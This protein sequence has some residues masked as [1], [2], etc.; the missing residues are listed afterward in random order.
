MASITPT[1]WEQLKLYWSTTAG[2][3]TPVAG[4]LVGEFTGDPSFDIKM[5]AVVWRGQDRFPKQVAFVDGESS[6]TIPGMQFDPDEAFSKFWTMV[7]SAAATLHG[8]AAVATSFTLG[9]NVKPQ[10]AEFLI[11]GLY[12]STGKKAQI[13]IPKGYVDSIP[14]TVGRSAFASWSLGLKCLQ[15]ASGNSLKIFTET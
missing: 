8:G 6:V 11:E 5:G 9:A 10:T 3:A 15:D 4:N 2:G 7:K 13:L 1:A 12:T 14:P